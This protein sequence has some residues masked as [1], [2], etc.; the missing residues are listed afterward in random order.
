MAEQN[1]PERRADLAARR[2]L[3]MSAQ[4]YEAVPVKS[5]VDEGKAAQLDRLMERLAALETAE[6]EPVQLPKP[7]FDGTVSWGNILVLAG[8]AVSAALGYA[9]QQATNSHFEDALKQ[10]ANE[11]AR[12]RVEGEARA[13]KYAPMIEAASR[14][15]DAQA[16]TIMSITESLRQIRD[17]VNDLAKAQAVTDKALAVWIAQH[18]QN[19][20][21]GPRGG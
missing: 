15:N 11:I 10:N 2:K 12:V 5:D 16:Q 4:A 7:R 19:S 13:L 21:S 20:P 1:S 3:Q 9:N 17:L 6:P 14:V 18:G 8:F